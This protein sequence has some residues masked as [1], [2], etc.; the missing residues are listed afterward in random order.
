MINT[1]DKTVTNYIGEEIILTPRVIYYPDDERPIKAYEPSDIF[2]LAEVAA[3]LMGKIEYR[4]SY[5]RGWIDSMGTHSEDVWRDAEKPKVDEVAF[6]LTDER[7]ACKFR[8]ME[9]VFIYAASGTPLDMFT[10]FFA[11][12]ETCK[13]C[14]GWK[15][16]AQPPEMIGSQLVVW[17]TAEPTY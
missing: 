4:D 14:D 16:K 5:C 6:V 11:D 8:E 7:G 9:E 17:Y 15:A 12:D 10:G 3:Q 2:S 13:I 1:L